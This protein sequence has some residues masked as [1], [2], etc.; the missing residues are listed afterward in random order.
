[1]R[2]WYQSYV[3]YE[4]GADFCGDGKDNDGDGEVN[5]DGFSTGFLSN[6]NY[7][8]NWRPDAVQGGGKLYPM[9]EGVTRAEV[10]FVASGA[11]P[12]SP[13]KGTCGSTWT[14]PAWANGTPCGRWIRTTSTTSNTWTHGRPRPAWEAAT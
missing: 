13:R 2:I 8:G 12:A 7:P 1:M 9:Q 5:E 4:N 10:D 14:A 11:T 3:D 6:R